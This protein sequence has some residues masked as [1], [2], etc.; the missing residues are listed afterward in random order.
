MV[1]EINVTIK[2]QDEKNDS[3]IQ[4]LCFD[5]L[6]KIEIKTKKDEIKFV[7]TKKSIDAR[8]GQLKLNLKFKAY[9]G[10]EPKDACQ[11]LPQWKKQTETKMS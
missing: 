7:F 3:L 11:R 4:R 5:Q 2:A 9:I 6:F 1:K 8:H 10:E